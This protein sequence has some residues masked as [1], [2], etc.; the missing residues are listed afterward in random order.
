MPHGDWSSDWCA[1]ASRMSFRQRSAPP[2]LVI[3]V[4]RCTRIEHS[5]LVLLHD[6]RRHPAGRASKRGARQVCRHVASICCTLRKKP[7]QCYLA[8]LLEPCSPAHPSGIWAR[9][10][11]DGAARTGGASQRACG[12]THSKYRVS[13]LR[14]AVQCAPLM[15]AVAARHRRR[16]A[17][18]R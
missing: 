6:F 7:V 13:H 1:D 8:T 2:Q 5:R 14:L 17:H 11:T 3:I 15:Q 18:V 9:H 4:V 16:D 12:M 10:E